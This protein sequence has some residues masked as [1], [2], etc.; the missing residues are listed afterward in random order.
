MPQ[1]GAVVI[2]GVCTDALAIRYV[3][4]PDGKSILFY[5]CGNISFHPEDV[6]HKYCAR[7]NRFMDLIDI[8]RDL[9][10]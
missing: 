10:K 7:C 3:I 2:F 5:P 8:A 9:S 1:A 6:R 4:A